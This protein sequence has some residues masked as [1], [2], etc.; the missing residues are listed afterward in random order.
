MIKITDSTFNA[1]KAYESNKTTQSA[2]ALVD[3][4]L[5]END[6]CLSFEALNDVSIVPEMRHQLFAIF[7]C[8]SNGVTAVA[9]ALRNMASSYFE[10]TIKFYD[11]ASWLRGCGNTY[12]ELGDYLADAVRCLYFD[13][14][15]DETDLQA[16]SA[17]WWAPAYATLGKDM[18]MLLHFER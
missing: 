10:N 2:L 3:A 17:Y 18:Q 14:E 9:V 8:P 6:N 1:V 12:I 13:E 5:Q 15:E 4:L 7:R 11:L 16:D